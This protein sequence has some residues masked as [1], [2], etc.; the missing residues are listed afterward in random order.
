MKVFYFDVNDAILSQ[1]TFILSFPS[2]GNVGQLAVDIIL[3]STKFFDSFPGLQIKKIGYGYS[4]N[5]LPISGYDQLFD[6]GDISLC[7]PLELYRITDASCS[8]VTY[9]IHQRSPCI[10]DQQQ[11]YVRELLSFLYSVDSFLVIILTGAS[12]EDIEINFTDSNKRLFSIYESSTQLS[13]ESLNIE[14]LVI[15]PCIIDLESMNQNQAIP[16]PTSSLLV[17]TPNDIL[18]P[19]PP[20]EAAYN[21]TANQID[22]LLTSL[23]KGM[24]QV[25][26]FLSSLLSDNGSNDDSIG[27]K[28][29]SKLPVFIVG[30]YC[31]EG[32]NLVDGVDVAMFVTN[33]LHLYG[34]DNQLTHKNAL[35]PT[36]FRSRFGSSL[37]QTTMFY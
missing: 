11:L 13:L 32:D 29:N 33:S 25:K 3:S 31:N 6:G 12:T 23:P 19:L 34:G 36:S 14:S 22:L 24:S 10:K 5:V 8:K 17:V 30:K 16:P 21:S 28:L 2:H 4:E 1:S 20:Y 9:I 18:P 26:T 27:R 37:K 7:T 35:F 15:N